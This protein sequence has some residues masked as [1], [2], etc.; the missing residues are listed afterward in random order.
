MC[1]RACLLRVQKRLPFRPSN[2]GYTTNA[3]SYQG[4]RKIHVQVSASQNHAG[5]DH[6]L[7][8]DILVGSVGSVEPKRH[9][10]DLANPDHS[11]RSIQDDQG[12][13]QVLRPIIRTPEK[14]L[15]TLLRR[16][17]FYCIAADSFV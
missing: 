8:T 17:I 1:D 9:K 13:V 12:N 6:P 4:R 11:C 3:N 14:S 15:D 2:Y 7:W 5:P 16:A 10:C